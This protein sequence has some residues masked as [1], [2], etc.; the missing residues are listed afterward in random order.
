MDERIKQRLVG[1]IVLVSLAVIF[2]P[3]ILAPPDE[4]GEVVAGTEIPSKP[5]GIFRSRIVPLEEGGD[6]KRHAR[7]ET[8]PASGEGQRAFGEEADIAPVPEDFRGT[9][10]EQAG[11]VPSA[12]PDDQR[13]GLTAWAVQVGSFSQRQ[14]AIALRDRLRGKG[15]AAFVESAYGNDGAVTRVF[16]GPELLRKNAASAAE[17]LRA[18]LQIEGIV[19]RYP[20]G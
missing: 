18:E 16:V 4:T 7:P 10:E 5:A 19:V 11:A 1:A 20:G 2:I 13:L 6:A 9:N 17:K 3:M 12:G 15:H 8:P 14:N